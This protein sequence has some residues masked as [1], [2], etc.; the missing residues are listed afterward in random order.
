LVKSLAFLCAIYG[1][2]TFCNQFFPRLKASSRIPK[3][4]WQK[5]GRT[6]RFPFAQGNHALNKRKGNTMS[7]KP[8]HVVYHVK[9]YQ[10]NGETKDIW[11]RI[12]A[13]WIHED[14][15][16]FNQQLDMVPLDGRIVTRRAKEKDATS[17]EA[18]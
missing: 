11:T 8:T 2:A 3:N 16:G 9:S 13:A 12:G 15:D 4:G 6:A 10:S 1:L 7:N 17:D 14:G 5:R 18:A